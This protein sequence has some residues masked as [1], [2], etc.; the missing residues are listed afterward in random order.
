MCQVCPRTQGVG[1]ESSNYIQGSQKE[2]PSFWTARSGWAIASLGSS[3]RC[4]RAFI[5]WDIKNSP[6]TLHSLHNAAP[7]THSLW[8]HPVS[9]LPS[10]WRSQIQVSRHNRSSDLRTHTS[11]WILDIVT[12][13]STKHFTPHMSKNKLPGF[14]HSYTNFFSSVFH[15]Q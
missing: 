1:D 5:L 7:N 13:A 11:K 15:I 2:S 8:S 12:Q 9:S 3:L 14:H 10:I 6:E 4:K